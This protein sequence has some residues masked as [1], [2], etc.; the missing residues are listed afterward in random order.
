MKICPVCNRTY[1]DLTF[2][3]CL[4]DGAL[5]S[6]PI[7]DEIETIVSSPGRDRPVST[8]SSVEIDDPVVAINIAKQFPH[9]KSEDDLYT[10]TRGLWRMNKSRAKNARFAFAVYKGVI[11]EVYDIER[12]EPADLQF[13]E[14]WHTK[15]RSQGV[16]IDPAVNDGRIQFIGRIADEDIRSKYLGFRLP[17]SHGQNPILYFNC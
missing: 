16:E 10:V 5:L 6:A 17:K 2:S 8:S 12:W 3:F 1:S 9:A 11:R 15:L 14:F 13:R 7:D 4:E